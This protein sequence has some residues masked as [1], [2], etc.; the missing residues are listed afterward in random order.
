MIHQMAIGGSHFFEWLSGKYTPP[1][2]SLEA[3]SGERIDIGQ[4]DL[5]TRVVEAW[6]TPM[7]RLTVEQ[8]R[9]LMSQKLG[10]K[11]LGNPV[12]LFVRKY[13]TAFVTFY[14]GDLSAIALCAFAELLEAAP[15][16]AHAMINA[17]FEWAAHWQETDPAFARDLTDLVAHARTL[18]RSILA[19]SQRF[20]G[21]LPAMNGPPRPPMRTAEVIHIADRI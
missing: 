4:T 17:K 6:K 19:H 21:P 13:P 14:A 20:V 2:Q 12:C 10:L 15:D 18:A 5:T 1:T 16:G 11:W 9:L 3:L 8:V 7:D